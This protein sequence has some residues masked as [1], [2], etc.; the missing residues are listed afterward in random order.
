MGYVAVSGGKR[1]EV[2]E[3]AERRWADVLALKPDLAPAL[4]LQRRLLTIVSELGAALGDGRLPRLSLPPKYLA[5]KLGRG[6]PV[7]AG[8]PIPL[9]V[10][11]L[12]P[13]LL[14]LADALA[15]AGAADAASHI[16]RAIESGNI[17][18]GSLLAASLTR[19]QAAIRSGAAQRGLSADLVWLIAELAV[20][21]FVHALQQALFAG[22]RD[23]TLQTALAGWNRGYCPACGSWPALAEVVGGHRMLRCSFCSSAWERNAYAC[24]YCDESGEAFVTAAPNEERKDRR[25][26]ACTKCGGYL[27]TIDLSE[28]SPFPLLSISDIETTD[29]DVAA[30]EHGFAR[31]ALK[32]FALKR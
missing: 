3:T 27:K 28:L 31:P 10:P 15:S 23:S 29:L 8:E 32:D 16:R 20:S 14:R 19:N 5:A 12:A 18:P 21:P 25:V 26:E 11:L 2:L 22:A 6:V 13:A 4:S 1:A 7:F 24:I 17:E 9:P 30:M